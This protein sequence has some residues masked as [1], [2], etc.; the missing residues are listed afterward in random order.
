MVVTKIFRRLALDVVLWLCA[1]TL[2]LFA[3]VYFHGLPLTAAL[4]HYRLVLLALLSLTLGRI[5]LSRLIWTSTT[6][7]TRLLRSASG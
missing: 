6:I 3:Y 1:P 4:P 5:L 2:F 7:N